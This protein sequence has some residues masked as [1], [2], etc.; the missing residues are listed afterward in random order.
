MLAYFEYY[1]NSRADKSPGLY[2]EGARTGRLIM[3]HN[4]QTGDPRNPSRDDRQR[5]RPPAAT[6]ACAFVLLAAPSLRKRLGSPYD[7]LPRNPRPGSG[8]RAASRRQAGD[9]FD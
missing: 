8:I 4:R 3:W 6:E 5:R 2:R 9:S 7:R 1:T